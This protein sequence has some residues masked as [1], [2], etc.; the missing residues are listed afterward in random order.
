LVLPSLHIGKFKFE[1]SS[2]VGVASIS[3]NLFIGEPKEVRVPLDG[4]SHSTDITYDLFGF[5]TSNVFFACKASGHKSWTVIARAFVN[6]SHDSPPKTHFVQSVFEGLTVTADDDNRYRVELKNV[7]QFM[8]M[9]LDRL[10]P[11]V[12]AAPSNRGAVSRGGSG[13]LAKPSYVKSGYEDLQLILHSQR[14]KNAV[15]ILNDEE[16]EEKEDGDEDESLY[17][18]WENLTADCDTLVKLKTSKPRIDMPKKS[19]KRYSAVSKY[20][21]EVETCSDLLHDRNP[22]FEGPDNELINK[23][24]WD[25]ANDERGVNK[26]CIVAQNKTRGPKS[27]VFVGAGP[28]AS[29]RFS[30]EKS[31]LVRR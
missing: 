25:V 5:W 26:K 12:W 6:F 1:K 16:K 9:L 29:E 8:E 13:N 14:I 18:D 17:K 4:L 19:R 7:A 27:A 20:S 24:A 22:L 30:L 21:P 15:N 11:Q 23:P 28:R 31:Y 2:F 10:D 3:P